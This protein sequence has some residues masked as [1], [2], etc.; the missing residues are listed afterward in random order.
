ML[1]RPLIYAAVEI[2]TSGVAVR[3]TGEWDDAGL[4][5]AGVKIVGDVVAEYIKRTGEHFGGPV[6]TIVFSQHRGA[7]ARKSAGPSPRSG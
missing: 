5:R 1:A 7:T 2:D 3:S 4:E 6:K